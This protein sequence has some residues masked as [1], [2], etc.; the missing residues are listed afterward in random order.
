M[1][2][3]PIL[4]HLNGHI[5]N[6]LATNRCRSVSLISLE[7]QWRGIRRKNARTS[8]A[9]A[10]KT[11]S[12]SRWRLR[13][14]TTFWK[15]VG[16]LLWSFSFLFLEKKQHLL[17]V[18][19][20]TLC[21]L[22]FPKYIYSKELRKESNKLKREMMESKHKAEQQEEKEKSPGTKGVVSSPSKTTRLQSYALDLWRVDTG[23]C[24]VT[25]SAVKLQWISSSERIVG[26]AA[27]QTNIKAAL[28]VHRGRRFFFQFRIYVRRQ[29]VCYISLN[30][31]YF[32]VLAKKPLMVF[33]CQSSCIHSSTGGSVVEFSPATREARV[34]FPASATI[35]FLKR[36]TNLLVAPCFPCRLGHVI[37]II[38]DRLG[39]YFGIH[40]V[41]LRRQRFTVSVFFFV[42]SASGSSVLVDFHAEQQLYLA[43]KKT[44]QRRKGAGRDN[45]VKLTNQIAWP[46][47]HMSERSRLLLALLCVYLACVYLA[48]VSEGDSSIKLARTRVDGKFSHLPSTLMRSIDLNPFTPKSG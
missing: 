32:T 38:S 35:F 36:A 15:K 23:R 18:V 14:G 26:C 39:T 33:V 47:F 3:V 19:R 17:A 13:N 20:Q 27:R 30:E 11:E 2:E 22:I 6:H 12:W 10:E 42:D 28:E 21:W 37:T 40:S 43:K 4:A 29:P 7:W 25:I 45:Q 48:C 34:R 9:E 1:L 24:C 31:Q 46:Q 8:S 16:D 41:F 44:E 5:G